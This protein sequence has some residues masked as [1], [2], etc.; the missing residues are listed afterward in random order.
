MYILTNERLL[1]GKGEFPGLFHSSQVMYIL[2]QTKASDNIHIVL[3]SPSCFPLGPQYFQGPEI[4]YRPNTA[5][6]AASYRFMEAPRSHLS[7]RE[8]ARRMKLKGTSLPVISQ[9]MLGPQRGFPK[10]FVEPC[11]VG[12]Q[13]H[14]R[15]TGSAFLVVTKKS[16]L[17]LPH[18]HAHPSPPPILLTWHHSLAGETS[19]L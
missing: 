18:P 11:V 1:L 2:T 14:P 8:T 4:M 15:E 16:T 5:N 9:I 12:E 10:P 3:C 6:S 7:S 17:V 19:I 13:T